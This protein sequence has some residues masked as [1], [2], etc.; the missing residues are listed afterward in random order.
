MVKLDDANGL[1][2]HFFELSP[3]EHDATICALDREDD[4]ARDPFYQQAT[5]NGQVAWI[6]AETLQSLDPFRWTPFIGQVNGRHVL[7]VDGGRERLLM[8]GPRE[9]SG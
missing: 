7:Y 1:M 9:V 6:D 3:A 4:A 8:C 2:A 5:A